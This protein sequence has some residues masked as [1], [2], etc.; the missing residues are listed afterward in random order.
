MANNDK[1]FKVKNGLDVKGS[2]TV[3]NDLLVSG[4]LTA[5]TNTPSADS[6]VVN[7]AYV[8]AVDTHD[9]AAVVAQINSTVNQSYIDGFDTHDSA[10]VVGQINLEVDK[11]FVDALNVDADTVDGQHGAYYLDYNN[12]TNTPNILDSADV[13]IIADS[14]VDARTDQDLFT[15]SDV[16]FNKVTSNLVGSV[17]FTAKNDEGTAL[18]IGDVVYIKG[19]SGNTPTVAKADADD[20]AKMPAFGIVSSGANNGAN[21]T[22]TTFGEIANINT[23][24][25][26]LGDT[27]YVSTT[28]GAF[29]ATKPTGET[30]L[31]QNV[32]QVTRV[33]ASTGSIKV[34]GAGRTAA[35]PNLDENNIFVGNASGQAITMSLDSAVDSDHVQSKIKQSFI[36]TFDTHDSAAVTGQINSKFAN[37]ATFSKDLT[38]D[39]DLT[40]NGVIKG[41]STF[42]IDPALHGDS[43]GTLVILGNLQ[44]DGV[45]TV[46]QSNT[47]SITDKNIV[48][49]DSATNNT[50][51][52]G[53][54]ITVNGANA[55]I[56]YVAVGDKWELNKAPY[57]LNDRLLTTADDTH[58]SAAVVGQI[59]LEVDKAFVDALNINA[60]QV[61]GQH[62]AYYLDYNNFTNIPTIPAL[63]TDYVD[64]AEVNT[65][66]AAADT[67]DSAAVVGQINLEVDQAFINQFDTHDSAAVVGQINLEVDKAFVDA[68]AVDYN[69]LSNKPTIPALGT[70]Y[71]DSAEVNTLIAA[72]DTH[73]SAAVVGQITSNVDGDYVKARMLSDDGGITDL[74][75][76]QY[77]HTASIITFTVTVASKTSEHRYS[78]SGSTNAYF[79]EGDESPFIQLV[80]GNV[81]RFDG[82]GTSSSHPLKFYLEADKTTQYTTGVTEASTYTEISV[83][84]N[85]PTVL[86]YQ[87]SVHG[88]MG[89]AVHTM[90][91]SFYGDSDVNVI[92]NN[93]LNDTVTITKH[94]T[95]DPVLKLQSTVSTSNAAPI[96]EFIRNT[97]QANNGDYLGQIKFLGEDSS[98]TADGSGIVYAKMT[99]KISDPTDG[100]EDGLI[101]YMVKSNGSNLIMARMT[102]NNGGKLIMENGAGIEVASGNITIAGNTVLTTASDTHDSA[103]VEGQIDSAYIQPLARAAI[104]A[105]SNITYDSATGV[106]SSTGGGGGSL[107]IEDEGVALATAATTL[108][109]VGAGVTASGTGAEKTITISGGGGSSASSTFSLALSTLDSS[110]RTGTN[111]TTRLGVGDPV[112]YDSDAGYWTGAVDSADGVASHVIVKYNTSGSTFEIAQ[113][114]IHDLDSDG[115][116]PTFDTNSYYFLGS[117]DG[118]PTT[119]QPTNGIYQSLYYALDNNT[120]DVNI[121]EAQDI[122]ASNPNE[123]RITTI[124]ITSTPYTIPVNS[125]GKMFVLGAGAGTLNLNAANFFTGDVLTLYNNSASTRTLTFDTYSDAVRI[126]GDATSYS[127]SS[128]TLE[129]YGMASV[130]AITDNGLIITGG[131]S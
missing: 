100:T 34:L 53:A 6:D 28:A 43:S 110:G 102:G 80:P 18:A 82:F 93:T 65:L 83:T 115:A 1:N 37:D 13:K 57:Y 52:N 95:T 25:F 40:V 10:A 70:D 127:A 30:A 84:E 59:N 88:Y 68:L 9:S 15:T 116:S 113:S 126:P 55:S 99:G 11:A 17:H 33:H 119:T 117:T 38:V 66:I 121:A 3:D 56:T 90:T 98:G 105:G 92:I 79:I 8:D 94:S 91:K 122:T 104:V 16:E 123:T 14:A 125:T 2:A 23:S 97:D 71:V 96:M 51:A 31:L 112:Y 87:C 41:P 103:A 49:A 111:V 22:V 89:N 128:L 26:S 27:L 85:T 32:G 118:V 36:N 72:A 101:E 129:A 46:I 58:D 5:K 50:E 7:K 124:N 54:G 77:D 24:T 78:G 12:F 45:S 29:T 48:L 107:T 67:H 60:D 21:V 20:A 61:D 131:V 35:T 63:G 76:A 86:Y 64:S 106:I 4:T 74:K 19:I 108:N 81:Y 62:G 69:A 73:D 120:I 42:I 39:S 130:T 47:V 75:Y 114:G 109:F 44:V